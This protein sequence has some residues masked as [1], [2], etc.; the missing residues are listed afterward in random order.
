MLRVLIGERG[1]GKTKRII[2]EANALLETA[3]GTIVYVDDDKSHT[4]EI[5]YKIRFIDACEYGINNP[6]M[7]TGFIRGI[8][9]QDFDIEHIFIDGFLKITGT[10]L[11]DLNELITELDG[12][13][14]KFGVDITIS[15]N[16]NKA[17]APEFLQPY[18][19]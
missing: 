15:M 6:V 3:K 1:I 17:N 4:R 7:F 19:V 12:F 2:D 10:R 5:N 13:S 18:L 14:E 11:E 9:A 8:C 16:G